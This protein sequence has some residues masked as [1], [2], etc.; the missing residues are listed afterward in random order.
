MTTTDKPTPE[1]REAF[2]AWWTENYF[3]KEHSFILK[4]GIYPEAYTEIA[5]RGFEAAWNTRPAKDRGAEPDADDIEAGA[6][7]LLWDKTTGNGKD[8]PYTRLASDWWWLCHKLKQKRT[9][10]HRLNIENGELKRAALA[11]PAAQENT[12]ASVDVWQ[13][14]ETAPKDGT[15]ILV[16]SDSYNGP[17]TAYWENDGWFTEYVE[18]HGVKKWMPLPAA[19]KTQTPENTRASVDV[20]R[21]ERDDPVDDR[22]LDNFHGGWNAFYDHLAE[23][24]PELVGGRDG[25]V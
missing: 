22:Y 25:K 11:T 14:I 1:C 15:W 18:C 13:D 8:G 23:K 17:V 20:K 24:F 16:L 19:Q 21:M 12:R 10:L 5:W 2:E 4:D 6:W 7:K 9:E 3:T